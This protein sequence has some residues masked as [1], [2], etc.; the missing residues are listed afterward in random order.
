MFKQ[1]ITYTDF[2]GVERKEDFHF[3]LSLPEVTRIEAKVGKSL[4]D[5]T[6][7]LAEGGDVPK[8]LGF[9][10]EVILNA[11][12]KKTSDGKSFHKSKELREEFEN[13][14]AYAE[15]FEQLI[16]SPDLARKFGEGVADNG[17]PRKNQVS[18]SVIQE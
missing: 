16:T 4:A 14:Q 5:H 15:L 2:N 12:G 3:H 1:N 13:S 7:E 17:K 10:E 8:L 9:L 18:P 6:K 11:Y